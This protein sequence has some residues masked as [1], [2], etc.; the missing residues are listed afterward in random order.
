MEGQQEQLEALTPSRYSHNNSLRPCH[1]SNV[2]RDIKS[3]RRILGWRIYQ[4]VG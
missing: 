4:L 3:V 2:C 1:W